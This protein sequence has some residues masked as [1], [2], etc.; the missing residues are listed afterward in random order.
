MGNERK[1][2]DELI[3][4]YSDLSNLH[5]KYYTL[6]STYLDLK[7]KIISYCDSNNIEV[8]IFEFEESKTKYNSY[9]SYIVA[10]K[11]ISFIKIILDTPT[12]MYSSLSH[13][14]GHLIDSYSKSIKFKLKNE[15]VAWCNG[16]KFL[17][18]DMLTVEYFK[19]IDNNFL[20]YYVDS[21]IFSFILGCIYSYM[22]YKLFKKLKRS[23][24][25][26]CKNSI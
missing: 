23:E 21:N 26:E 11:R 6:D 25:D 13:E 19:D 20:T 9:T 17:K 1:S 7:R 2:I 18:K 22:L 24:Q 3:S 14:F 12:I 8:Y 5:K 15:Y 10:N 4:A 16:M